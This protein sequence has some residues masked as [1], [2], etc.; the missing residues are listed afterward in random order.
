[1]LQKPNAGNYFNGKWTASGRTVGELVYNMGQKGLSFAPCAEGD[2]DAY[3]VVYR[4][5]LNY[6]A[7][8]SRYSSGR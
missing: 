4:Q 5:M 6:D 3:N 8:L 2:E 7:G 1:M